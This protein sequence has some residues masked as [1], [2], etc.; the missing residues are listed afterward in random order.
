MEE[1]ALMEE[2]GREGMHGREERSRQIIGSQRSAIN[3][4]GAAST[5]HIHRFSLHPVN[6]TFHEGKLYTS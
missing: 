4:R 1:S 5:I 3:M 6:F 2:E